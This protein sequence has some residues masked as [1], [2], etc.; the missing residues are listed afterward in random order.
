ML[1]YQFESYDDTLENTK[2]LISELA[3]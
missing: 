1:P 3:G 2:R